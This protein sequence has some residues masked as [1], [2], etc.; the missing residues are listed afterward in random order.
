MDERAIEGTQGEVASHL[1]ERNLIEGAPGLL[2]RER[3][4]SFSRECL[5][6][7][8]DDVGRVRLGRPEVTATQGGDR[9]TAFRCPLVLAHRKSKFTVVKYV[10]PTL[11]EYAAARVWT[12]SFNYC[13]DDFIA[14]DPTE[15]EALAEGYRGHDIQIPEEKTPKVAR[16]QVVEGLDPLEINSRQVNDDALKEVVLPAAWPRPV[17]RAPR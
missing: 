6:D 2:H 11:E 1:L 3:P 16:D 7:A 14:R 17:S 4:R 5:N 15:R 10:V 9:R 12:V 8:V 13:G